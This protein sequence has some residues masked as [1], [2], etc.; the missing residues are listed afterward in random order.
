MKISKTRSY[1]H[2]RVVA[3]KRGLLP[4]YDIR[5]IN[6]EAESGAD[7]HKKAAREF[8]KDWLIAKVE[9]QKPK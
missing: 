8:G 6:I 2:Y 9:K 5:T 4:P 3:R 1:A 7:A